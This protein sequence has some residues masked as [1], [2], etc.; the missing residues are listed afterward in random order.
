M[1]E[2]YDIALGANEN[3]VDDVFGW[4]DFA[5][6]IVP[7]KL[8]ELEQVESTGSGLLP[9]KGFDAEDACGPTGTSTDYHHEMVDR[10]RP[11]SRT[12]SGWPPALAMGPA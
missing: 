7:G 10:K 12:F 2:L 1:H 4:R 5:V 9:E 8:S 11:A 6:A 3:V